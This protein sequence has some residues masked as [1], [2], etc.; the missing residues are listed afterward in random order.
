MIKI[1]S[2]HWQIAHEQLWT[3]NLMLWP[4]AES[5]AEVGRGKIYVDICQQGRG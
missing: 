4:D 2:H 3:Y 5:P 1:H